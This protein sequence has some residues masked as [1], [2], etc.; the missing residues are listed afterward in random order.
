M[1][2]RFMLG[3]EDTVMNKMDIILVLKSLTDDQKAIK[4]QK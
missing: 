4:I 3:A 2:Q 1:C